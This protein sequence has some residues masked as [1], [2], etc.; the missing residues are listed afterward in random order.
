MDD[1]M[2]LWAPKH[3]LLSREK[4]DI[5]SASSRAWEPGHHAVLDLSSDL[6]RQPE[7]RCGQERQHGKGTKIIKEPPVSWE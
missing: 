2:Q 4:Q 7:V 3:F 6:K 5:F 1:T